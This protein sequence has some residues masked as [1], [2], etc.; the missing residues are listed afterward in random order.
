MSAC[1]YLFPN[2]VLN[3][4]LWLS[5]IGSVIS[6]L[7]LA[8]V[9]RVDATTGGT[10]IIAR[11]IHKRFARVRLGWIFFTLDVAVILLSGIVFRELQ[12]VIL[13]A[14]SAAV[15]SFVFNYF[16]N[17]DFSRHNNK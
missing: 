1:T 10:D 16:L 14:F 12:T 2:T 8:I 3:N 17:F 4:A 15:M 11:L 9:F 13:S 5:L 7:G 6:G